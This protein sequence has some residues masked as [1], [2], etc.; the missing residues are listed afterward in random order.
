MLTVALANIVNAACV[1][2]GCALY[3]AENC[4]C[5]GDSCSGQCPD[6]LWNCCFK[7]WGLG[8][9]HTSYYRQTYSAGNGSVTNALDAEKVRYV[10]PDTTWNEVLTYYSHDGKQTGIVKQFSS[11]E[12]MGVFKIDEQNKQLIFLGDRLHTIHQF[13]METLER[14]MKMDSR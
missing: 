8:P 6:P 11:N 13:T 9:A 14:R 5:V 10:N 12:K 7:E 2:F 3:C 1:G 4:A